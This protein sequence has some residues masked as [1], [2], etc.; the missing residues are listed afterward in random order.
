MKGKCIKFPA[1]REYFAIFGGGMKL[2]GITKKFHIVFISQEK[3]IGFNC[4]ESKVNA[5]K[6]NFFI[7]AIKGKPEICNI[8]LD[9]FSLRYKLEITP[10]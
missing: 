1:K 5:V 3:I 9:F 2:Q 10:Y 7:L 6:Y 4:W 8:F